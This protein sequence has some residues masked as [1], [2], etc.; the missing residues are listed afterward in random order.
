[1]SASKN[2]IKT[3][4]TD[5]DEAP[6]LAAS[7]WQDHIE[8]TAKRGVGR[9]P[10]LLTKVS[11]TLRLDQDVISTFKASGSGW[12]TRMNDALRKAAGLS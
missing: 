11:Q 3:D 9:P 2:S 6:D 1:M 7:V 4:W 5:A 12:Q 10:A 8:R